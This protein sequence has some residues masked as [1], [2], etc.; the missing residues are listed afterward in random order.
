MKDS[1]VDRTQSIKYVDDDAP[2]LRIESL[3]KGEDDDDDYHKNS[4]LFMYNSEEDI[5]RLNS[6]KRSRI[7]G[8][9][10]SSTNLQKIS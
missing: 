2:I 5:Y 3:D 1:K 10:N 9:R 7:G 4:S 6:M 8:D